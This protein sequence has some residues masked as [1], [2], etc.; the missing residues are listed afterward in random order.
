M[1]TCELCG[2]KTSQIKKAKIMGSV[3]NVCEKCINY[4]TSL[5]QIDNLKN[6]NTHKTPRKEN[7]KNKKKEETELQIINEATKKIQQSMSQKNLNIKNFS[8]A[9]NVKEST[10]NKIMSKKLELDITT[11][12]KIEKFLKINLITKTEIKNNEIDMEDNAQYFV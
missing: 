1:T 2:N 3:M 4:G 7:F 11:A 12:R 8:R 10:L 5:E 9:I 6:Q